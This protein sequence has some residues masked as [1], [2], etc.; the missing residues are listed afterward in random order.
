M[1]NFEIIFLFRKLIFSFSFQDYKS[2]S[3]NTSLSFDDNSYSSFQNQQFIDT[4]SKKAFECPHCQKVFQFESF[5]LS[6][7]RKHSGER[8][9]VCKICNSSFKHKS[10]L[11][12]HFKI[13]V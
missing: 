11:K 10:N 12:R 8:P 13:H 3:E 6:H 1:Q 5:L 2:C 9:F 4:G 7:I